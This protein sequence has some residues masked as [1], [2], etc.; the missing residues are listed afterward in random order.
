MSSSA[1]SLLEGLLCKD[2]T[3]RL[4]ANGVQ[5]IMDHEF[6]KGVDWIMV[7]N[8]QV[9]CPYV[10]KVKTQDDVKYIDEDFLQEEIESPDVKFLSK[11][12]KKGKYITDFSFCK[13][14]LLTLSP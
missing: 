1:K 11:N 2:P 6:F 12:E 9:K 14:K 7:E 3:K 13:D 4:G 10:P 5:E 8:R